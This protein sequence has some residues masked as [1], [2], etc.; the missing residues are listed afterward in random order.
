MWRSY[1]PVLL[2]TLLLTQL[3]AMPLLAPLHAL[4]LR[5]LAEQ[6]LSGGSEPWSELVGALGAQPAG[7]ARPV[8]LTWL[9]ASIAA[10]SLWSM[11]LLLFGG[12]APVPARAVLL[13][14]GRSFWL[15]AFFWMSRLAFPLLFSLL[16][17]TG[18]W[19]W[20]HGPLLLDATA[21][22][23]L[24]LL[25]LLWTALSLL[26]D[27]A[28]VELTLDGTLTGWGAARLGA[29]RLQRHFGLVM[30]D[31]AG[32]AL[33]RAALLCAAVT[34]LGCEDAAYS[35]RAPAILGLLFALHVALRALW[36]ARALRL[37]AERPLP[38]GR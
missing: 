6:A 37:G 22:G 25:G 32:P 8:L 4:G 31:W 2:G 5:D 30:L 1:V 9:V 17:M 33:A 23:L 12:E 3:S 11:V 15:G 19:L 20:R 18:D 35:Q 29:R 10:T 34:L 27:L 14:L 28:L 26:Q 36:L 24:G 13:R 38:A 21:W 7:W 16:S